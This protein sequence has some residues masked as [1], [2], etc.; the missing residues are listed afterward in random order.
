MVTVLIRKLE[1]RRGRAKIG[2]LFS[3]SSFSPGL[4]AEELKEAKGGFVVAML[5]PKEIVELIAS[6]DP[7]EYL[8]DF[9]MYAMLR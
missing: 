2:L 6:D 1:T 3:T 4:R 7:T 5:G 9:V 8:D